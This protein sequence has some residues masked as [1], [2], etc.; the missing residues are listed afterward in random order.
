[1]PKK[2]DCLG[3][4]LLAIENLNN[5]IKTTG[6]KHFAEFT[7]DSAILVKDDNITNGNFFINVKILQNWHGR[8]FLVRA[9]KSFTSL[10]AMVRWFNTQVK[11]LTPTEELL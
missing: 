4:L 6:E 9:E 11:K 7:I 10:P 2:H 8:V 3:S 5:N 1:M